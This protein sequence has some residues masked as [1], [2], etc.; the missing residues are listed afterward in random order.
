MR[1]S[2]AER[3]DFR[4][5][6]ATSVLLSA[7]APPLLRRGTFLQD[8]AVIYEQ[9]APVH[10]SKDMT[11]SY[12]WVLGFFFQSSWRA[13]SGFALLSPPVITADGCAGTKRFPVGRTLE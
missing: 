1:E 11:K 10:G 9:S 8:R 3:P 5:K 4:G 2:Q 7:T 13:A 12:F 6:I